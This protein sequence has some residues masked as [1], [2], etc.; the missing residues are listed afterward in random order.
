[1][2]YKGNLIDKS[3]TLSPEAFAA[4]EFNNM[5]TG[6]QPRQGV[7]FLLSFRE[8]SVPETLENLHTLTLLSAPSDF[9]AAVRPFTL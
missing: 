2:N 5:F 8:V 7:K 9:D 1:M 6:R 3:V 4:T